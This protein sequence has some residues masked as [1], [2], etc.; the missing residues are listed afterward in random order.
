MLDKELID[1]ERELFQR[2]TI[3]GQLA[4][5][6]ANIDVIATR[7]PDRGCAAVVREAVDQAAWFC[8]WAF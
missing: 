6:R 4:R 7:M 5:L 8:E 2:D 1:R 3:D